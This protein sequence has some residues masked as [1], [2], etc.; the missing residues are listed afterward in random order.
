MLLAVVGVFVFL[1][2]VGADSLWERRNP[3]YAN[4]FWDTKA[5]RVGDVVTIVLVE[6]TNFQGQETRTLKKNTINNA[7]AAMNGTWKQGSTINHS[8]A[9]TFGSNWTS[10]RELNGTS[11][12]QSNRALTDNMAVQ[13]IQVMANGNLVVEGFR[14]RVIQGEERTIRV[15]GIIRPNDI[16][17]NNTVQS[18]F[19][20]NLTLEYFGKGIESS[21]TANGWFGRIMN[22]LWPF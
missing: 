20:G 5:R 13:V 9:G 22:R 17:V 3:Y 1:N 21:Y 14:T 6:T 10:D 19:V 16:G 4:M 12:L 8:F 18:Q 2:N 11:N 15:S 7:N